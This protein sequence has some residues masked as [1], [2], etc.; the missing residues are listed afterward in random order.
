ML[1][2]FLCQNIGDPQVPALNLVAFFQE[3]FKIKVPCELHLFEKGSHGFGIRDTIGMSNA[4][5]PRLF[6]IWGASHDFFPAS[7]YPSERK[8]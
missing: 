4:A 8:A 1:P 6:V 7:A 3:L 5:W 2:T